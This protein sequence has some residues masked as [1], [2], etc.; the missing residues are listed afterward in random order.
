MRL[1][2]G[3]TKM[4]IYPFKGNT[5]TPWSGSGHARA[6]RNRAVSA[7]RPP[8]QNAAVSCGIFKSIFFYF[9]ILLPLCFK[10]KSENTPPP[11]FSIR[12]GFQHPSSPSSSWL[13]EAT[14][15]PTVY[16]SRGPRKL[17]L[18]NPFCSKR[19]RR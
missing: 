10:K 17:G 2:I 18:F 7:P 11:P 15:V 13:F 3:G 6:H 1:K 5:R 9:F 12:L 4:G 14:V 19:A 8:T 16:G